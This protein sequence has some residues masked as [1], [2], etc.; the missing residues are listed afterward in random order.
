MRLHCLG[1]VWHLHR[2]YMLK[3]EVLCKL[4]RRALAEEK[5]RVYNDDTAEKVDS[6]VSQA[7][8]Y[9]NDYKEMTR[10]YNSK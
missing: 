10:R 4:L 2:A 9:S 6:F 8:V 1:Q 5:P 3:S 7:D